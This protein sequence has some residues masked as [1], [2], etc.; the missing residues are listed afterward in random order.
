MTKVINACHGRGKKFERPEC[1]ANARVLLQ[2]VRDTRELLNHVKPV[3]KRVKNPQLRA[4]LQDEYDHAEGP[5]IEA[6]Q[7]AH[8]FVFVNSEERLGVA[9]ARADAL[10]ERVSNLHT[11][12]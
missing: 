5:L 9:R 6:V 8:A 12:P 2:G 1:A 7:A 10:V 3:I 4:S 11:S